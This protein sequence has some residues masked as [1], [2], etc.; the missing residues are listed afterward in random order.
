MCYCQQQIAIITYD[1]TYILLFFVRFALKDGQL[2]LGHQQALM[3][4]LTH[5]VCLC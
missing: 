2:W 5:C 1:A 4:R 3:V